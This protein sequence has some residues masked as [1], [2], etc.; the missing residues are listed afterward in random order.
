L[1]FCYH[2][3]RLANLARSG[4]CDK[5]FSFAMLS[6]N[7]LF[8]ALVDCALPLRRLALAKVGVEESSY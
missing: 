4:F 5:L 3:S 1:A 8:L 2:T 7:L 6:L